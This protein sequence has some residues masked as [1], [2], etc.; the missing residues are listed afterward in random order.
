MNLFQE[1]PRHYAW[2][3]IDKP[4][5]PDEPEGTGLLR[6]RAFHVAVEHNDH[7]H[8]GEDHALGSTDQAL[9]RAAAK[10]YLMMKRAGDFPVETHQ[11]QKIISEE[12]Q[13][14]GR[15]DSMTVDEDSGLWMVGEMKTS[16]RFDPTAYAIAETRP[17]TALYKAMSKQFCSDNFLSHKDFA[18]LSYKQV[19]FP[20]IKPLKGR[21]KNAV[22]ETLEDFELRAFGKTLVLHKILKVSE[23]VEKSA[24]HA[25]RHT[26]AAIDHLGPNSNNYPKHC[27]ACINPWGLCE[28]F[29]LCHGLK[30]SMTDD[31]KLD[32]DC[33]DVP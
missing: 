5:L 7:N 27:G 24:V 10:R 31:T 33:E 4:D 19:V 32:V 13:F 3:Y 6:G 21:G 28:D 2:R 11:E 20:F 12:E 1:C 29:E 16:G 25:F 17:Q 8:L 22:P 15:V 9:V 26:L 30:V 23:Q 18:G 14:Y